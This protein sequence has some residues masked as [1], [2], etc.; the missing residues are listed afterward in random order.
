MASVSMEGPGAARAAGLRYADDSR[1]GITRRRAGTGFAY[2]AP[3]GSPIHARTEL[4]RIRSIAIPPAWTDVWI[5]P[6]PADHL[7]AT[8][9]DARGRKQYRYH[10]RWREVRDGTKYARMIAFATA[11]PK[12]RAR[13][14]EDL[15]SADLTRERVLAVVVRLLESTLIRV[16]NDEYTKLN[17]S[18]GLTTMR[19]EHVEVAGSRIRFRFRGKSGVRHD[20]DVID[21]RISRGIVPL[22]ELPRHR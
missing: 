3:D 14:D 15:R 19:D 2:R 20:V 5:S 18:F 4:R 7:Q 13:T 1:P 11:L 22:H 16:G 10:D 21:R 8:G 17:R 9:R 12:I 6:N